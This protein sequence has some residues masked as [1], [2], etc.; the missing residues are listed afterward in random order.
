MLAGDG[1]TEGQLLRLCYNN[2]FRVGGTVERV[3]GVLLI[4]FHVSIKRQLGFIR[5]FNITLM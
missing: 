3:H 1:G 2:G 5:G 4:V